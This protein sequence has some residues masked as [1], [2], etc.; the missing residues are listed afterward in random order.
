MPGGDR[1]GPMGQ[2]PMTG[3]GAGRGRGFGAGL[4]QG[5]GFGGRGFAGGGWGRRNCWW[6]G[7]AP[8]PGALAPQG[9]DALEPEKQALTNQVVTLES[10]LGLLKQRLAEIEGR[11]Q[12]S[13]G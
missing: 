9:P 3:R 13:A 6:Q 12:G 10:E 7:R 2:G 11:N 8:L 5:C 4:G 1:T